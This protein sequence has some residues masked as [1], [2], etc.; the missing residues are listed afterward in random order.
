M[1]GWKKLGL[2][3]MAAIAMLTLSSCG[4]GNASSASKDGKITIEFMHW[5]GTDTYKGVYQ[6]RIAAFEKA[7]PKIKVKVITVGDNYDTKLLTMVAGNK[8]P[9]VAQVAEDGTGFASKNAFISLDSYIKDN[10][11]DLQKTYGNG[12]DLY[13]WKGH[14]FG[15]PDR[16]GAGVLYYNKDIFDKAHMAYPN[17]KWTINDFYRAAKK[18]TKRD[19]KGNITQWGTS[20]ADYQAAWGSF[21]MTNGGSLVKNGKATVDSPQNLKTFTDYTKNF[22]SSSI[23]YQTAEDGVNRFQQG[24]VAMTLDG[25]WWILGNS[26]VKGLNFDIAP[27]PGKYS[28]STGSALTI[29]RQSDKAHRAAS[30][31]FIKFMTDVKAQKILGASLG[32]IPANMKVLEDP[33][34]IKQKITGKTYDLATIAKDQKKVKI[35]GI[36]R[37]PWY[38]EAIT[39]C[40][41]EVKEMLLGHQTPKQ[42][43]DNLQAKVRAILNK[44]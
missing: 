14:V 38:S 41:N 42:S 20:Y 11:M 44:Y 8:A 25:M 3:A 39:E 18:L 12:S 10:N 2:A 26:Q 4:S 34:F 13:K 5:G 17:D 31:K 15:I 1:K 36:F 24:K 33:G 35:D 29:S 22:K 23:S 43:I 37:G 6:K 19:K 28:W 7:N 27:M 16:G 32:D 40:T 21:M 9:D 30:W